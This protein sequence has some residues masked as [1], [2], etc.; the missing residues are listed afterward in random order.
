V[1][2]KMQSINFSGNTSLLWPNEKSSSIYHNKVSLSEDAYIDIGVDSIVDEY[3]T[4]EIYKNYVK[5]IFT[6]MCQDID[7]INYRLDILDDILKYPDIEDSLRSIFAIASEV[8]RYSRSESI[9]TPDVQKLV[10]SFRETDLYGNCLQRAR[11]IM[12]KVGGKFKSEGLCKLRDEILKLSENFQYKNTNTETEE[13]SDYIKPSSITLGINLDSDLRPMEATIISVNNEKY[14][15]APFLNKL[16]KTNNNSFESTYDFHPN[17]GGGLSKRIVNEV[18]EA[19]ESLVK[20]DSTALQLSLL[21]DL[22]RIIKNT[23]SPLRLIIHRYTH[24]YSK[25][26]INLKYELLFFLGSVKIIKNLQ[27]MG[28]PMTRPKAEEKEKRVCNIKGF[29]NINLVGKLNNKLSHEIV[30]NDLCFSEVGNIFVLTGP[31]SGGKTTYITALGLI[32]VLFQAGIYVPAVSATLSPV[33]SIYT[34]FSSEEKRNTDY[35]RLGEEAKRLS[36]IFNKATKYSFIILNESLASTSP[37]ECLYMSLDI[38]YGLKLLDSHAIFA[39]HQHELAL[40]ADEINQTRRGKGIIKSLVAGSQKQFLNS[41]EDCF[42]RTYK[43]IEAPPKG[44]SYA[45]DI[46]K[47]F[48][49][50]FERIEKTLDERL[51]L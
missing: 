24:T 8:E 18:A 26:F 7:I 21:S 35:G 17:E 41:G 27:S 43:V 38:L 32:Q 11:E 4:S 6:C 14:T 49:I 9:S 10:K 42:K 28:L 3:G 45:K 31:N 51:M 25:F 29:F 5:S 44:I 46:A 15:R 12:L 50:S 40:E 22:D 34:H 20:I 30:Q 1:K 37:T 33:D 48:G 39:T 13:E 47:S 23:I 2:D 36:D 16:I 19:S